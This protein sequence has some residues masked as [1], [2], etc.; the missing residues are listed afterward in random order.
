MYSTH[1]QKK[2]HRSINICVI[3]WNRKLFQEC[4]VKYIMFIYHWRIELKIRYIFL[5]L[6]YL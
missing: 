5:Y 2:K 3:I 6:P 1:P 4:V